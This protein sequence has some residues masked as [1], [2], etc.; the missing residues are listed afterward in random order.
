MQ[1][2]S[3]HQLVQMFMSDGNEQAFGE[4]YLRYENPVRDFIKKL[5]YGSKMPNCQDEDDIVQETFLNVHS[6]LK[7]GLYKNE[8]RMKAWIFT[9]AKNLFLTIFQKN[10]RKPVSEL[11]DWYSKMVFL[12][13][14]ENRMFSE[15]A[16]E[17]LL[18]SGRDY[19]CLFLYAIGLK[20]NQI[21][22]VMNISKNTVGAKIF[23]QRKSLEEVF[24]PE[25]S[26]R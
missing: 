20:Y 10:K 18:K 3:D 13:D 5:F 11:N 19:D 17:F 23:K 1:T 4:I 6:A 26:E 12:P 24:A 2:L 25:R 21:A 22:E 15:R 7:R 9:V 16:F 8:G 14:I